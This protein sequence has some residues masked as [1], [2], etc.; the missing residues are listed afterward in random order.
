[1]AGGTIRHNIIIN[2]I[3]YILKD[4]INGKKCILL[5]ENVKLEIKKDNFYVYPDIMVTC[6]KSDFEDNNNTIIKNPVII[7]EV[8]SPSTEIY[9]R[10]TKKNKYLKLPSLKYYLIV[11]QDNVHIEM[12]EKIQ[13]KIFFTVYDK[14]DKTIDFKQLDFKMPVSDIYSKIEF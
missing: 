3:N 14:Q 1:M 4:L 9:D 5:T 11:A 2:E 13:S 10:N 6:D 12:Y 7:I 8:L